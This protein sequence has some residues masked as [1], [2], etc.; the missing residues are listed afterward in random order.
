M[1]VSGLYRYPYYVGYSYYA[2]TRFVRVPDCSDAGITHGDHDP[3]NGYTVQEKLGRIPSSTVRG[4]YIQRAIAIQLD[5]LYILVS[6]YVKD[7]SGKM[8]RTEMW[9]PM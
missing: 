3:G 1:W 6:K 2:G 4:N 9:L 7:G 8:A 5:Q